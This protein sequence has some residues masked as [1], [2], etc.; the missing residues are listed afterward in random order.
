MTIAGPNR[1]LGIQSSTRCNDGETTSD[2]PCGNDGAGPRRALEGR[3]TRAAFFRRETIFRLEASSDRDHAAHP[4][5][6]AQRPAELWNRRANGFS[7]YS[8]AGCVSRH[9]C[10]AIPSSAPGS[11]VQL[12]KIPCRRNG[13]EE[14]A[15]FRQAIG[16]SIV[17]EPAEEGLPCGILLLHC[18][19]KSLAGVRLPGLLGQRRLQQRTYRADPGDQSFWNVVSLFEILDC[20]S[21]PRLVRRRLPRAALLKADQSRWSATRPSPGFRFGGLRKAKLL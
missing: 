6:A 13:L 1:I 17:H 12:G 15:R 18:S 3:G 5:T 9:A 21:W 11:H 10:R 8:A 7:G 2:L 20:Y 19:E 16:K 4:L 14:N